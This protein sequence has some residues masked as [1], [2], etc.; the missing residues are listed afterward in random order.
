MPK[1]YPDP[2]KK[3]IY[4]FDSTNDKA[5]IFED[6]KTGLLSAY[7]VSPR[8]IIGIE[9]NYSSEELMQNFANITVKNF[10]NFDINKIHDYFDTNIIKKYIKN[11]IN[12]SINNIEINNIKLKGGFISDVIEIKLYTDT[13]IINCVGKM[14]N[15]NENFLTQMSHNLDLYNREYYFYKHISDKVPV[16]TPKTKHE[17]RTDSGKKV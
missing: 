5:I 12:I 9:T 10:L 7:S 1:P 2:Y 16:E 8:C 11:S 15:K 3:A 14:E 6:S 13:G 17:I 4:L